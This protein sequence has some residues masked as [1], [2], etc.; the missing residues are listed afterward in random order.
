MLRFFLVAW[1]M[2]GTTASAQQ[3]SATQCSRRVAMTLGLSP[4]T[5]I[6]D[7]PQTE[8]RRLL[9]TP[10]VI[11][12][13]GRFVNSRF[14]ELPGDRPEDDPVIPVIKYVFDNN[15]PWKDVFVGRFSFGGASGYPR[16]V[17]DAA[18]PALGYFGSAAWQ[19]RYAGNE[20]AG[21]ML[22]AAYRTLQNT[23]G[24]ALE[25][26]PINGQGDFTAT[27]RERAE[28]RS[29]HYDAA[30]ALDKVARLLPVRVGIGSRA[31][32]EKRP[33]VPQ[34]L[35]GGTRVND[36][37]HLVQTLVSSEAFTFWSCRLAFEY[38]FG[39][40]ES[41]CEAPL[42]D[43]CAAALEQTGRMQDALAT[44]LESPAFCGGTP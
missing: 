5:R 33:V 28:C 32:I 14:N 19:K 13:F 43:A 11:S 27:G 9:Q 17:A 38:V 21:W 4:R 40:P 16:P 35:F 10:E 7:N 44:L 25:P 24:L 12:S 3:L 22:Q 6:G 30:W 41:T 1:V 37:E 23:T 8:V 18:A 36:H 34:D 2:L 29:C 20:E 26:S 42:F 31:R 39:R 15:L